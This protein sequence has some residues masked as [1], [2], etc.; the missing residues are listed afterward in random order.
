MKKVPLTCALVTMLL[1]AFAATAAAQPAH[2]P[3]VRGKPLAEAQRI[4]A[5]SGLNA[6][7]TQQTV[8]QKQQDGVVI[9]QKIAE[10]T[11][12]TRGS[13]VPLIVGKYSAPIRTSLPSVVGMNIVQASEMLEKQGWKVDVR[14]E[15]TN[16]ASKK[17]VVLSQAP[18][19]GSQAVPQQTT[20]LLRVGFQVPQPEGRGGTLKQSNPS[21]DI[22]MP[23]TVGQTLAYAQSTL[24]S[25]GITR[26]RIVVHERVV[27]DAKLSAGI[28][29][30][31]K[32][33]PGAKVPSHPNAFPV[34]L[35]VDIYK[36]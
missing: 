35:W 10:G 2:V 28:V 27:P 7:V 29:R 24:V 22:V 3:A 15:T 31:Q 1:L 6:Q 18:H 12:V 36:R 32:P 30:S 20:V 8:A 11:R 14:R 33:A 9:A 17:D 21:G 34:E 4:L 26:N 19:A 13:T 16:D 5:N 25:R 23:H